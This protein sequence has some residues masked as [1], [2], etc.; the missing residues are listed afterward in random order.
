[1]KV[2][3]LEAEGLTPL[4]ANIRI[5]VPDVISEQGVDADE[6]CAKDFGS[7]IWETE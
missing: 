1:M 4:S 7:N 6:A 5:K 3:P 2:I